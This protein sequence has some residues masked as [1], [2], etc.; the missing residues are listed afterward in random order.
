[1]RCEMKGILVL[2][3]LIVVQIHFSI[4]QEKVKL[5]EI[6]VEPEASFQISREATSLGEISSELA[7]RLPLI[8]N[9][10]YR[11]AQIFPG[12][13]ASDFSARFHVRGGDLDEI[14]VRLDGVPLYQPYHL[15]DFGGAISTIDLGLVQNA[16]LFMGGYPPTYGDWISA[17]Y[18]IYTRSDPPPRARVEAGIDMINTDIMIDSPLS[19][20]KNGHWIISLRRGYIDLIMKMIQSEEKFEPR[21]FD[22]FNKISFTPSSDSDLSLSVLYAKDT[23]LID[24][25]GRE[26][27]VNSSYENGTIW[28]SWNKRLS[29]GLTLSSNI[30]AGRY[31][32]RKREGLDGKDDRDLG[33]AGARADLSLNLGRDLAQAGIELQRA[34]G[35]YD[36][37]HSEE[38]ALTD[39]KAELRGWFLRGYLQDAISLSGVRLNAGF[40]WWYQ[41]NGG[42]YALSPRISV[43]LPLGQK[44]TIKGAWGLFRQPIRVTELPIEEGISEIRDPQRSAH[45]ILGLEYRP[46]DRFLLKAEA[47]RKEMRDLMGRIEDYGRKERFFI[48]ADSGYAHGLEIFLNHVL[49]DRISWMLGYTYSVAKAR[50]DDREFFRPFDQRHTLGVDLNCRTGYGVLNLSW[51]FHTG[52]PYTESWYEKT[53]GEWIKRYGDPYA[54]RLPSYHSLDLRFSREFEFRRWSLNLYLQVMNVYNRQN[55]HEYSWSK[56]EEPDGRVRYERVEE[57]YLPILPTFG[58]RV[59]F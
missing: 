24:Q 5:E 47:Y 42:R 41:G 12:V 59:K 37:Y 21:Y 18:D 51:R 53:N 33:F 39:V 55:V 14:G 54:E 44:L 48:K 8:D 31:E 2:T 36:Y 28:A 34:Y 46:S 52:N 38:G 58:I 11:A 49:S 26:N 1:M 10:V 50:G 57:H 22:L 9:D 32:G 25:I 19:R 30:F 16:R 3:L 7:D 27:D 13:T 17:V 35:R 40:G 45:Y 29:E 23:N 4:A 15:Q 56:I 20:L 43:F 6:V